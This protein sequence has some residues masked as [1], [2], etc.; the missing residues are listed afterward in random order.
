M[1]KLK[2]MVVAES[3]AEQKLRFDTACKRLISHKSILS[4]ILKECVE[5]FAGLTYGEIAGYIEG[6]VI[7]D[8]LFDAKLPAPQGGKYKL[9]IDIEAQNDN[10]PGYDLTAR[11]V[12][13]CCRLISAQ[14]YREFTGSDYDRI[15]KVY[16]IWLRLAPRSQGRDRIVMYRIRPEM[17][18]GEGNA[19]P[20]IDLIRIVMVGLG[21]NKSR[22][23]MISL[24]SALFDKNNGVSQKL[25]ALS[26]HGIKTEDNIVEGVRTMCNYSDVIWES[27]V[28]K[29][30]SIGLAEGKT[31]GIAEGAE[32]GLR[33]NIKTMMESISFDEAVKLLKLDSKQVEKLRKELMPGNI[34]TYQKKS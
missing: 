15:Q 10:S 28:A 2:D 4:R 34:S 25:E 22:S 32:R 17:I 13:Y 24:L 14:K 12:Y 9:I 3:I 23:E 31:L 30:K 26:S 20:D 1:G 21:N 18:A 5:E 7:Y 27:G 16:S 33:S 19:P 29:G 8:V 6:E 11:A